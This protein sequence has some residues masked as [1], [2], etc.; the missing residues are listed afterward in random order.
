MNG[1][2]ATDGPFA[3]LK[4]TNVPAGVSIRHWADESGYYFFFDGKSNTK[5]YHYPNSLKIVDLNGQRFD[6]DRSRL[7][8][9]EFALSQ[10][11]GVSDMNKNPFS[12]VTNGKVDAITYFKNMSSLSNQA[13]TWEENL[14]RK[15]AQD[16]KNP[17]FQIYLSDVLTMEALQPLVRGFLRQGQVTPDQKQL[18]LNK[19]DE[20]DRQL[21]NAADLS[22]PALYSINKFPQA[23]VT[24]PLAPGAFSYIPQ[25]G[26]A[27]NPY[28]S[29]WGGAWDQSQR[30]R[31]AV[32]F[33]KGMIQSEA[34]KYFELPPALPAR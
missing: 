20:A 7:K 9:N 31:V 14:L 3:T 18:I 4:I 11:A 1:L 2:P 5:I 21:K 32:A 6:V 16:N 19:L 12:T 27:Y 26:A 8:V 34:Y 33:I 15:G 28:Y 13:L 29:F 10:A 24:M 22:Y 25:P 23:N 17:Y 30:R